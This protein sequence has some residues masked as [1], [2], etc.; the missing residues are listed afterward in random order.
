MWVGGRTMFC[1]SFLAHWCSVPPLQQVYDSDNRE[2]HAEGVSFPYTCLA[3]V[4]KGPRAFRSLDF[5]FD[6]GGRTPYEH[7]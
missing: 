6:L 4:S 7:A 2:G 3:N 1:S 5:V